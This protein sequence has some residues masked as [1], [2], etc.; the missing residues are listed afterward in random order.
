MLHI[1]HRRIGDVTILDLDGRVTPGQAEYAVGRAVT[2]AVLAGCRKLLL[3]LAKATSTDTAGINILVHASSMMRDGGGRLGLLKIE[4]HYA[5]M[6]VVAALY[7]SFDIFASEQEALARFATPWVEGVRAPVIA[8]VGPSRPV[9]GDH[10]PAK[11]GHYVRTPTL[12][13]RSGPS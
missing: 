2:S 12:R 3:N 7:S 4:R 5:Q 1:Q 8:R 9:L 13:L 6:L 11:A 10:G